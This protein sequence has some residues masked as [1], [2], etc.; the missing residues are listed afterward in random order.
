MNIQR[1]LWG[2][3]CLGICLSLVMLFFAVGAVKESRWWQ[4]LNTKYFSSGATINFS[5]FD[6]P[7]HYSSK[8]QWKREKNG[9]ST[10]V[11]GIITSSEIPFKSTS[12]SND[13]TQ[14]FDESRS[15]RRRVPAH[16]TTVA[17]LPKGLYVH[18]KRLA[19]S[20]SVR[21]F[22][23]D[24]NSVVHP[25]EL[26]PTEMQLFRPE[27]YP[28]Q[29][30]QSALFRE[31]FL[32]L[33]DPELLKREKRQADLE[34]EKKEFA[35][36]KACG[37]TR[38]TYTLNGDFR[39]RSD[40]VCHRDGTSRLLCAFISRYEPITS[41]YSSNLE[42]DYFEKNRDLFRESAPRVVIEIYP[43]HYSI[44]GEPI[45]PGKP[46]IQ[47]PDGTVEVLEL[48]PDEQ[49]LFTK[50]L[51][52]TDRVQDSDLFKQKIAPLVGPPIPEPAADRNA[53]Q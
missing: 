18:K 45:E 44:N 21:I 8:V 26:T 37:I 48:T 51:L 35:A 6:R 1:W 14:V 34:Q 25:I 38:E 36:L 23:L 24:K 11:H 49:R 9:E 33:L 2:G 12:T 32:P 42:N 28:A 53:A 17:I 50:E 52:S 41:S 5:S 22:V 13:P 3:L 40:W 27:V 47:R 31:K 30:A 29:L 20:E 16:S 10:L 46:Y 7:A 43:S 39:G 4:R 19:T 15:P